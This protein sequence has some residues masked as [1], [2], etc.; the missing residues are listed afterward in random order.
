MSMSCCRISKW[1]VVAAIAGAAVIGLKSSWGQLARHKFSSA[2]K[3]H[4]KPELQIERMKQEI[5]KLDR[6]I[7]KNWGPIAEEEFAIKKLKSDVVDGQAYLDKKKAEMLAAATDLEAK[8]TKIRYAGAERSQ[9]DVRRMLSADAKTYTAKAREVE[10]KQKH[11]AARE[12]KLESFMARQQEMKSLKAELHTRLETIEADLAA[13]RL[14]ETK[15]KLPSGDSGR[16]DDIKKT[17][18]ELEEYLGVRT[19]ANEL[20]DAAQAGAEE[21]KPATPT[22]DSAANDD[23]IRKVRAVVGDEPKVASGNTDE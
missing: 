14:A 13:L 5:A 11:L 9:S 12:R 2:V 22:K 4:I 6:D 17:M 3:S 10:A 18:N 20:R 23:V 1:V 7:D 15:S 16:L 8:A 21:N 19:R